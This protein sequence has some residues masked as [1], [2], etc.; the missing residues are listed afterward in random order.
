LESVTREQCCQLI[1]RARPWISLR[2][3]RLIFGLDIYATPRDKTDTRQHVSLKTKDMHDETD[4]TGQI[5]SQSRMNPISPN[6]S[7]H[8]QPSFDPKVPRATS[9]LQWISSAGCGRDFGT[10]EHRCW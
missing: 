1:C 7:D 9:R 5:F 10:D 4:S 2:E 6:R 8:T 3:A